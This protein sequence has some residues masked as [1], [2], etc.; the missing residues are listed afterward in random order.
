MLEQEMQ[1]AITASMKSWEAEQENRDVEKAIQNSLEPQQLTQEV[2]EMIERERL[3]VKS[4]KPL[5]LWMRSVSPCISILR[6]SNDSYM[7]KM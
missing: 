5:L 1:M 2:R 3:G 7:I 6:T 4:W